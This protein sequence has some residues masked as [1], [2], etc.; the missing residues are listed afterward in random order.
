[1]I[2]NKINTGT[3]NGY[4]TSCKNIT[5]YPYGLRN[6]NPS[7]L[8]KYIHKCLIFWTNQISFFKNI[9]SLSSSSCC[10]HCLLDK[11]TSWLEFGPLHFLRLPALNQTK[12]FRVISVSCRMIHS[13]ITVKD[14]WQ[15]FSLPWDRFINLMNY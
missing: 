15:S 13:S 8:Y 2:Y 14:I 7:R 10:P 4:L 5:I 11:V 6:S 3:L 12:D 9:S 1:M